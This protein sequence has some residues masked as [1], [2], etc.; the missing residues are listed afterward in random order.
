MHTKSNKDFLK[1]EMFYLKCEEFE[2]HY[3]ELF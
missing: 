2:M 1:Y 3:N